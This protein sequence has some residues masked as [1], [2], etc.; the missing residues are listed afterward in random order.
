MDF[1]VVFL[2]DFLILFACVW[3]EIN[4][5]VGVVVENFDEI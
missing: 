1:F 3:F 5:A 2:L 4:D